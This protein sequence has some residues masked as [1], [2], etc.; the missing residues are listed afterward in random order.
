MP[1]AE[2]TKWRTKSG[3]IKIV[4]EKLEEKMPRYT[5]CYGGKYPLALVSV[6]SSHTL[7]SIFTQ[8]DDMVENRGNMRL[9]INCKDACERNIKSGD[10]ILCLAEVGFE[11]YVTDNIAVGAVAAVGVYTSSQTM[12]GLGVNAL[13]HDR[14]SDLGAATTMND[15]KGD[16]KLM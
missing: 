15:N 7:N 8:R 10:K 3:K 4:N 12:N 6:P 2:H 14:L 5:E 13:H 11:A 16:I 1:F 9:I